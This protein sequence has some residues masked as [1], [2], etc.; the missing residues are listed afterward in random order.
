MM[1]EVAV[2]VIGIMIMKMIAIN[3]AETAGIFACRQINRNSSRPRHL[4]TPF[5]LDKT[6]QA[7][8]IKNIAELGLSNKA[9]VSIG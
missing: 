2:N 7:F 5:R 8:R 9:F 4:Q 6:I 1:K 3:Q